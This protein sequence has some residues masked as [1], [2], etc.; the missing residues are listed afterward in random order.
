MDK[1]NIGYFK[2]KLIK[3]RKAVLN[4]L[5]QMKENNTINST[6][7]KMAELSFYDNHPADSATELFDRE[8]N[9]ALKGEQV[10]ILRSIDRALENLENGTYGVCKICGKD[11]SKKRLEFIPYTELCINCKKEE[12][13]RTEA[14]NY[15]DLI[16]RNTLGSKFVLKGD[17]YNCNLGFDSEDAYQAVERF[18]RIENICGYYQ[19]DNDGYVEPIEKISNAQYKNGLP[20]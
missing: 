14:K 13:V 4:L 3:E 16:A 8:K 9:L 1:E 11:I 2:N 18:N 12:N 10:Y 20:D 19:E 6:N 17:N 15:N 5:E 7:Q